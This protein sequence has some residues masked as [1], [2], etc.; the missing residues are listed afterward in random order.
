MRLFGHIARADPSQNYSSRALRAAISRPPAEW[1]RRT[2]PPRSL[3]VASHNRTGHAPTNI[4]FHSAWQCVQD[5]RKY[6][7]VATLFEGLV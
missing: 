5:C 3:D 7:K 1:R 6:Q 2:G 4:D